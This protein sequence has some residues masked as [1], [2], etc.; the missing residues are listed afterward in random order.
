MPGKGLLT[1]S[2]T[3]GLLPP[4]IPAL[5]PLLR[6]VQSSPRRW[7]AQPLQGPHCLHHHSQR[8]HYSFSGPWVPFH[9]LKCMKYSNVY[10]IHKSQERVNLYCAWLTL[11]VP[12]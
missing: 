4:R 5:H 2:F 6:E 3:S 11:C 12:S 10:A 8:H 9:V 7:Q 1:L